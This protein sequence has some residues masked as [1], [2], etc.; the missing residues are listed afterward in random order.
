MTAER[1]FPVPSPDLSSPRRGAGTWNNTASAGAWGTPSAA[2][3]VPPV[4][5]PDVPPSASALAKREAD[6]NRREAEL[7]SREQALAAAGG[8]VGP[9]KNWPPLCPFTH[10]DISG[11]IPSHNR[12]T[13]RAAYW[14]YLGLVLCMFMNWIGTA[15]ALIGSGGDYLS[16]F[17]WAAI[18]GLGGIPLAWLLWYKS[19]YRASISDSALSYGLFFAFYMAHLIFTG[20]SAIAPPILNSKSHCGV[21]SGIQ[22]ISG[23]TGVG[24]MYFIAAGLWCLEFIWSFWVLKMVYASF[25][26]AKNANVPSFAQ[27]LAAQGALRAAQAQTQAQA[28]A[29]V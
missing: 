6:L 8:P 19:L 16:S 15:A 26:G 23:N 4:Q 13:V 14:A 28:P 9:A 5:V 21:W 29:N 18:Y 24:V 17:L 20:W 2:P 22:M 10:H 11:D 3:Y 12:G 27:E 25:R 1:A 7:R